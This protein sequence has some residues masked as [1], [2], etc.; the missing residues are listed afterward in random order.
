VA[1]PVIAREDLSRTARGRLG[2]P[3]ERHG[4]RLSVQGRCL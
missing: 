4:W 2:P 3:V 1:D